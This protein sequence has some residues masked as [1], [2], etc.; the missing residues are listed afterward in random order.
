MPAKTCHGIRCTPV[1][2]FDPNPTLLNTRKGM[3]LALPQPSHVQSE[4][5][6]TIRKQGSFKH[7]QLMSN[8]QS[9]YVCAS[10]SVENSQQLQTYNSV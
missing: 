7:Q 1:C 5:L 9:K 3:T 10:V 4:V 2:I 6:Q 8:Q